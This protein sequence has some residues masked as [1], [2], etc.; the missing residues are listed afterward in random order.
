M[1]IFYIF[2]DCVCPLSTAFKCEMSLFN[3]PFVD[4][5]GSLILL[6][7]QFF[8][9]Q[10]RTGGMVKKYIED[11]SILSLRQFFRRLEQLICSASHFLWF[12]FH[13]IPLKE[14]SVNPLWTVLGTRQRARD[15]SFIRTS[16]GFYSPYNRL[17][18]RLSF[19]SCWWERRV[20]ILSA[21]FSA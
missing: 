11:H 7:G 6:V 13:Y 16:L 21:T 15:L 17:F 4:L 2:R 18:I 12:L 10:R 8:F 14:M 20:S 19:S 5:L 3:S 9:L 1:F